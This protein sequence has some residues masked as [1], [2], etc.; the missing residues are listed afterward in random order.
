VIE[1]PPDYGNITMGDSQKN[2][3]GGSTPASDDAIETCSP[4]DNGGP[5]EAKGPSSRSGVAAMLGH[6]MPVLEYA[7][8]I[9][10]AVST[11]EVRN[12]GGP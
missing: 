12:E 4:V 5:V 7:T 8:A 9:G 10:V 11:V 1:N 6:T 2:E 3:A